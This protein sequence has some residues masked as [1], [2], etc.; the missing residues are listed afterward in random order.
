MNIL[1]EKAEKINS[2]LVGALVDKIDMRHRGKNLPSKARKEKVSV[3]A[4]MIKIE[5]DVEWSEIADGLLLMEKC[6]EYFSGVDK[7]ASYWEGNDTNIPIDTIIDISDPEEYYGMDYYDREIRVSYPPQC[8]CQILSLKDLVIRHIQVILDQLSITDIKGFG[9]GHL[10]KIYY[11]YIRGDKWQFTFPKE[12]SNNIFYVEYLRLNEKGKMLENKARRVVERPAE[13]KII[14]TMILECKV[15]GLVHELT[16]DELEE[17]SKLISKHGLKGVKYIDY[18][19]LIKGETCKE[20][21]VHKFKFHSTFDKVLGNLIETKND[22][23]AKRIDIGKEHDKFEERIKDLSRIEELNHEEM[24]DIDNEIEKLTKR[25]E[26][27]NNSMQEIIKEKEDII[28][29]KDHISN[30]LKDIDKTEKT[31]ND[32][33]YQLTRSSDMKLWYYMK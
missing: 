19:E 24:R 11:E 32:R 20:N 33:L 8:Q 12:A 14:E 22:N 9:R 10:E 31:V 6:R 4:E 25:R 5:K 16:N 13:S 7:K 21:T 23:I 28:K 30:N 15:C 17:A 1:E 3:T 18:M 29:K 27:L 2:I 26:L